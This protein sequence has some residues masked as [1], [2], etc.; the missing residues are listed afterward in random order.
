LSSV[1]HDKLPMLNN[2]VKAIEYLS[3][4]AKKLT[5][6]CYTSFPHSLHGKFDSHSWIEYSRTKDNQSY[7]PRSLLIVR[8]ILNNNKKAYLLEIERKSKNE[9]FSGLVFN[10]EGSLTKDK[11]VNLLSTIVKHKGKYRRRTGSRN[12]QNKSIKNKLPVLH[13]VLFDHQV[14]SARWTDKILRVLYQ[15]INEGVFKD[16]NEYES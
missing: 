9:G 3:W 16:D 10:V 2:N 14:G 13:H 11:L 12:S 8:V 6:G 1:F 4:D 7:I 15:S 5:D